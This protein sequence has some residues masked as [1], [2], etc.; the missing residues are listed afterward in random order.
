MSRLEDFKW[1]RKVKLVN[2]ILSILGIVLAVVGVNML[3]SRY[4]YRFDCQKKHNFALEEFSLNVLKLLE[5][6]VEIFLFYGHNPSDSAPFFVKDLRNLLKEYKHAAGNR[7]TVKFIDVV[8][9]ARV[10]DDLALKFGSMVSDSVI[11]ASREHFRVIPAFD[12][13]EFK[14]GVVSGFC[15][16]RV[17]SDEILRLSSREMKKILFSTGHGEIDCDSVHPIYGSSGVKELLR[18]NGYFVE[19]INLTEGIIEKKVKLLVI[20]G[21]QTKFTEHEI[22][23][24][25]DFLQQSGRI[26][27]LLSSPKT[28]GLEDLL[29]DWGILADDMLIVNG[30][31]ERLGL[32]GDSIVDR[33][34]E[35]KATQPMIDMQLR[36][37]FGLCQPVR[38]DVGSPA[39]KQRKITPLFL[40]GEKTFAK[41]DYTQRK[42]KY[43]AAEDLM[44]P[45]PIATLSEAIAEGDAVHGG[46]KLLAIGNANFITN[47]RFCVLGNKILFNSIVT[48]LLDGGE[49]ISA[50]V[51]AKAA[52]SYK[53]ALS[54]SE[55]VRIGLRL[56]LIPLLFLLFG[57]LVIYVR[58]N[59]R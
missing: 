21:P 32:S 12:L 14:D 29:F 58:R 13:Y 11:I 46:G 56:L 59:F 57:G 16:E 55:L 49:Q 2:K 42:L 5:D 53:I 43:N 26:L 41:L 35:H 17:I 18:Q 4:F 23:A 40:S 47:H 8:Q 19:K 37:F 25:T 6:P 51:K 15:G 7:I 54:R 3:S 31:G 24:L 1:A 30:N 22:R 36:A 9:Q 28:C 33:F 38:V 48:W 50:S 45:V 10:A 34:A 20:A 52:E 27:I 44:G 39:T